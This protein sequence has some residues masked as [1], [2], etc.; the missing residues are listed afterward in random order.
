M[1]KICHY[2][3][4]GDK[5]NLTCITV[6]YVSSVHVNLIFPSPN[7]MDGHLLSEWVLASWNLNTSHSKWRTPTTFKFASSL[8]MKLASNYTQLQVS[9][10]WFFLMSICC[11][12]FNHT[13]SSGS[14]KLQTQTT[15]ALSKPAYGS[16]LLSFSLVFT[17]DFNKMY[18]LGTWYAPYSMYMYVYTVHLLCRGH[19]LG[20]YL[21]VCI[22]MYILCTCYVEGRH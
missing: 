14:L 18:I 5:K 6:K 21:I 20:T 3:S 17:Y 16:S 2:S 8:A 15:S 10:F 1:S 4:Q 13:E 7:Q 12:H 9:I 19:A 11:H 22:C